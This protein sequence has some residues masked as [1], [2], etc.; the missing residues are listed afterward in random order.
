MKIALTVMIYLPKNAIRYVLLIANTVTKIEHTRYGSAKTFCICAVFTK[1]AVDN[2]LHLSY[3]ITTIKMEI[4]VLMC[5][6]AIFSVTK[7]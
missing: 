5:F 3:I 6:F 7:N 1:K 2:A 4:Y